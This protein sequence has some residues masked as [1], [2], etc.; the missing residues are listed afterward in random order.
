MATWANRV[1]LLMKQ[2]FLS[3]T[4]KSLK[5]AQPMTNTPAYLRDAIGSGSSLGNRRRPSSWSSWCNKP[6]ALTSSTDEKASCVLSKSNKHAR[7]K[8]ETICVDDGILRVQVDMSASNRVR[9]VPTRPPIHPFN[10]FAIA[11]EPTFVTWIFFVAIE[12]VL[13]HQHCTNATNKVHTNYCTLESKTF[14][15]AIHHYQS[16]SAKLHWW[17]KITTRPA[18]LMNRDYQNQRKNQACLAPELLLI[19]FH[20]QSHGSSHEQPDTNRTQHRLRN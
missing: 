2:F 4:F 7:S 18:V 13:S 14:M 6:I 11:A 8:Y 12:R 17:I 1:V 19:Y 15:H 3:G 10:A 16:S 5:R 20:E 9:S